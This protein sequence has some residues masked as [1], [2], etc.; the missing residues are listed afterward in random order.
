MIA[1]IV[2]RLALIV[3]VIVGIVG[4]LFVWG[5]MANKPQWSVQKTV[6]LDSSI[7]VINV[8][9][10]KLHLQTWGDEHK[11][12]VIGLH[13][14]PG[15]DSAYLQTLSQ[16]S[17]RF[18]VVLYDQRGSGLSE[19]VSVDQLTIE[20]FVEDLRQIIQ[21]QRKSGRII[22]IGHSWGAMLATAFTSQYPEYVDRMILAEPGFLNDS[23]FKEFQRR[24]NKMAIPMSWETISYMAAAFFESLQISEPDEFARDDYFMER[25]FTADIEGHP[26]AGYYK[27]G[28]MPDGLESYRFGASVAG[29]FVAKYLDGEGNLKLDF[30]NGIEAYTQEVLFITAEHNSIIGTDY[31]EKQRL[32]FP[33]SILVEIPDA[34]HMMFNSQ[35][36]ASLQLIRQWLQT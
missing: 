4:I 32:L 23:F 8:N 21:S 15:N 22:L 20:H 1:R 33:K 35:P 11:D 28:K 3:A 5:F 31:Q 7:P 19:R 13:G 24:T 29:P 6:A 10:T 30:T 26:L 14:G 36:K 27:D 34:G 16:L 2:K 18:K 12:V 17:D 9:G 25:I